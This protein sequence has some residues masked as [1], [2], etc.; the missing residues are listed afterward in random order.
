MRLYQPESSSHTAAARLFRSA[1]GEGLR[2]IAFTK[3]R[4]VT[5]L[6]HTWVIEAEPQLAS[7][8]SSYRAGFLP[9]ERREI[10]RRL[11]SGELTGVIS[12]SALEM[13]IDVGGLDVCIY[14]IRAVRRRP[15]SARAAG[16]HEKRSSR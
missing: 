4:R 6:L 3:S 12:T 1:V 8:V 14:R 5:E 10:E 15:G 7:R 9:E 13:G 2:T 16:V 11:F